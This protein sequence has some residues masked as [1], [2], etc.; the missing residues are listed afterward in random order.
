MSN[1]N[2]MIEGTETS[3]GAKRTWQ[4]LDENDEEAEISM[5]SSSKKTKKKS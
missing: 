1:G 2:V 4:L 5:G 3:D